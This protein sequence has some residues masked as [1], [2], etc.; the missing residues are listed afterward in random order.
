MPDAP[1]DAPDLPDWY[2]SRTSLLVVC[3]KCGSHDVEHR[4]HDA[5]AQL[6]CRGCGQQ[7]SV[8]QAEM[9]RLIRGS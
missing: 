9:D 5:I 7:Q 4:T 1:A 8:S 3:G 6:M 2:E